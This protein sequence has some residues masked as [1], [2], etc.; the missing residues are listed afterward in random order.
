MRKDILMRRCSRKEAEESTR[1]Q[2]VV[3]QEYKAEIMSLTHEG[4]FAGHLGRTKT[5]ERVAADFYWPG[6]YKDVE[7]DIRT[8]HVCQVA[9]KPN[10][11]I[12][13]PLLKLYQ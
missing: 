12:P 8:Y 1:E 9:C 2:V 4:L 11:I 3:P 6:I 10:Q 13:S 5:Y 7:E